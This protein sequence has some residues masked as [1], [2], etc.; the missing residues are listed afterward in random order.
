MF[1][2][3]GAAFKFGA[4][5]NQKSKAIRLIKFYGMLV[6]FAGCLVQISRFAV[7]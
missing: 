6:T 7:C 4:P 5:N 3:V 2:N 1:S